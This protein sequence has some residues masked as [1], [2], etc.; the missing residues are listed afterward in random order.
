MRLPIRALLSAL[1]ASACA[2]GGGRATLPNSTGSQQS[3]VRI[4][5]GASGASEIRLTRD[6]AAFET[7]V[8]T[9]PDAAF[10]ALPAAYEALGMP[11]NTLITD[12]RTVGTSGLRVRGRLGKTPLSR[13]LQCGIDAT[14][15]QHADSYQV[16]MSVMTRVNAAASAPGGSTLVTQVVAA[17]RP[18]SVSGNEIACTSTGQLERVIATTTM[19]RAAIA[20]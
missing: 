7:P 12:A 2:S 11:I 9:S 8:A 20:K 17:A 13:Y 19:L 5:G 4:D 18:M 10:A 3:T 15:L 1:L 14:G 6:D 16:Q